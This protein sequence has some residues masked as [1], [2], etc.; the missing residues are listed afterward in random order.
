MGTDYQGTY[1]T[2]GPPGTGKTRWLS[3]QVEH[4]VDS[5]GHDSVS[6]CS[7]TK[8]AAAEIAGRNLP[9]PKSQIGTLHSLAYRKMDSQ[10]IAEV[11]IKEWNEENPRL[12]VKTDRTDVDDLAGGP[13]S[14]LEIGTDLYNQYN[15]LRARMQRRE[16]WPLKVSMFADY[17]QTWKD[18]HDYL[19]FTDMI[20]LAL[21]HFPNAPSDPKVIIADEAQDMS[22]LEWALINSALIFAGDPLQALYEW[23]G[24]DP[25]VFFDESISEDHRRLLQQSFRVPSKVKNASMAWLRSEMTDFHEFEYKPD[26]R[27]T[28]G[29]LGYERSTWKYP[30]YLIDKIK[31]KLGRSGTTGGKA[32]VMVCATCGYMLGPLLAVLRKNGI[33]FSNP[34]RRKR[35][36]WNPLYPRRGMTS[37]DRL[38]EF[39]NLV[40]DPQYSP[41]YETTSKMLDVLKVGGVLNRGAKSYFKQMA[42]DQPDE[43]VPQDMLKNA[44]EPD[45]WSEIEHLMRNDPDREANSMKWFS[46]KSTKK[47]ENALKY[48]TR[49]VQNYGLEALKK[50]P[51]LYVGTMHSFKGSEADDVILFPD[52]SPSGAKE[53]SKRST[54]NGVVRTIYVGM[55]RARRSL[56]ICNQQGNLAVPVDRAVGKFL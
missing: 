36:D 10:P 2:N 55:T 56:T 27:Y 22:A 6:V 49:V 42:K 14:S 53:W 34:W 46:E 20:S 17:W 32:E 21:E 25:S 28:E 39:M 44:F 40:C 3:R 30:E 26:E 13:S 51:R 45:A 9:I 7:L 24:A 33:P 11:H 12:S 19:D 1:T 23:R 16:T 41:R 52:L 54:K 47:S 18:S 29:E 15:V 4:I 43:Y 48:V 8:A 35:G 50:P 5:Y 31:E 37:Q 38:I